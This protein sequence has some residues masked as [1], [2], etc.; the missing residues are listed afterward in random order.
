MWADIFRQV[1][2]KM[3]S[4]KDR[5]F[6]KLHVDFAKWSSFV[7]QSLWKSFE[8]TG[9]EYGEVWENSLLPLILRSQYGLSRSLPWNRRSITLSK[10]LVSF[11]AELLPA[12]RDLTFWLSW[13]NKISGKKKGTLVKKKNTINAFCKI[14]QV[15]FICTTF[16]CYSWWP[17]LGY[18][19]HFLSKIQ[20]CA[21][22]QDRDLQRTQ[23]WSNSVQH[24]HDSPCKQKVTDVLGSIPKT[25]LDQSHQNWNAST[26]NYYLCSELLL[27]IFED[28][29]VTSYLLKNKKK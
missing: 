28:F 14:Y 8:A 21:Y 7:C 29:A 20:F 15:Y 2:S 17:S 25:A 5:E 24:Q 10:N 3:L 22:N 16:L 1:L 23:I 26:W 9:E 18:T 11:T 4:W 13:T 19:A 12:A 27:T 6:I